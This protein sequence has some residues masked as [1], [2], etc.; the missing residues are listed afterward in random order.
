MSGEK[1]KKPYKNKKSSFVSS[2]MLKNINKHV[3]K[4]F[5]HWLAEFSF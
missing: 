1:Q 2:E 3:R 4:K 5:V